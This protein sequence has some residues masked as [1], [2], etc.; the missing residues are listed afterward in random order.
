MTAERWTRDVRQRLG[1]GRL[2]PLGGPLDGAWLAETAAREFLG[3]A[4]ADLPGVLLGG[5]RIGL[6]DPADTAEPVVPAP[7]SALPPGPLRLTAE[8]SATAAE[9][10]PAAA[11]RLRAALS[12][13]AT[14]G[15]GLAVT[16]VDL[17]VVA[18]LDEDPRGA[19]PESA[20]GTRPAAEPAGDGGAWA[21]GGD[22]TG[23]GAAWAA[24]G[25]DAGTDEARAAA[26]ALAVPGV[27]R[28][29]SSLGGLGRPVALVERGHDGTAALP[30]LH[31][32]VEIAVHA[33]HRPVDVAR[34]V[35]T[36]VTQ[37]L[38]ERPTV[39]VLVTAV[40]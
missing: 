13:A 28:L 38:P 3:R 35:R 26:A 1:L 23:G 21:A 11:D 2:L 31:A 22:D 17:R 8:F 9:P 40:D 32:R 37:S 19:E 30:R 20:D 34:A 27:A 15:L 7:P 6:A 33:G 4:C 25:G 29:T 5:V 36:A 12:A 24:G 18:L 16:Q 39:A 14:E 10:L